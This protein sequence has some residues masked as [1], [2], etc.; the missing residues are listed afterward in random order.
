MFVGIDQKLGHS[1]STGA[2]ELLPKYEYLT[3]R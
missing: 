2:Q 1:F 3:Q